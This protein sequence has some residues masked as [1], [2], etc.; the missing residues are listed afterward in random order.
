MTEEQEQHLDRLNARFVFLNSDKY[1]AGQAEHKGNLFDL[2]P[3]QLAYNMRDEALDAFNYAQ[4]LID[5]LV[6]HYILAEVVE[7]AEGATN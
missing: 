3:L 1:R 6:E 5:N 4:T 7:D 2:T